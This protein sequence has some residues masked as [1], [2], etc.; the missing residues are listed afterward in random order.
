MKAIASYL[1]K[2]LAVAALAI[3]LVIVLACTFAQ[4]IT[5][6]DPIAQDLGSANSLPTALHPLGADTLGRDLLSRL[7]F[8]GRVSLSGALIAVSVFLVLGV[9]LGMLAGSVR[10]VLDTVLTKIVEVLFAVP[11]LIILLVVLAVFSSNIDA[12]MITLGVLCFGGLFR[13]VRATTIAASGEL[14]VKAAR[15]SGLRPAAVLWRHILPNLWGPVIVQVSLFAASAV[16]VESGI[17]FLGFSVKAPDPSWGSML[18][19]GRTAINQHP[20]QVFTPGIALALTILAFNTLGDGIRDALG[21]EVR[22]G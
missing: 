19:K 11:V 22:R 6:Y 20:W 18:Q 2:P 21:R 13:I 12:A 5:P 9:P 4:F 15:A 17:A 8:G 7:L 10:G 1:R 14:Y 3:L 16:L